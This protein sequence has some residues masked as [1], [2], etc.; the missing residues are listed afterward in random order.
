VAQILITILQVWSAVGFLMNPVTKLTSS[1]K[2]LPVQA[3]TGGGYLAGWGE[4][5]AVAG[6]IKPLFSIKEYQIKLFEAEATAPGREVV[7]YV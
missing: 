5:G 1:L 2:T 3:F 6:V 7:L 4:L